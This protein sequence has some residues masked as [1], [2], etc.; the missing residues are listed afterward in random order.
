MQRNPIISASTSEFLHWLASLERIKQQV[1]ARSGNKQFNRNLS[2][3]S[4]EP[5]GHHLEVK[6]SLTT[7]IKHSSLKT[8]TTIT[9]KW[10]R[11]LRTRQCPQSTV[12]LKAGAGEER[13]GSFR[14]KRALCWAKRIG[15]ISK[16]NKTSKTTV[17]H[18]WQTKEFWTRLRIPQRFSRSKGSVCKP[19]KN[20][21]SRST[22]N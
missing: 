20:Q 14:M 2:Q 3:V 1:T 15:S 21:T 5:Q 16:N 11:S 22:L 10:P 13:P 8:W 9:R 17:A 19:W 4:K 18:S 7:S 6:V 12:S